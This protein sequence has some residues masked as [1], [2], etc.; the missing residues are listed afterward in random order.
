M[1]FL[2]LPSSSFLQA[3]TTQLE[4]APGEEHIRTNFVNFENRSHQIGIFSE[5][6]TDQT[7][8]SPEMDRGGQGEHDNTF[9]DENIPIF[10]DGHGPTY[11]LEDTQETRNEDQNSD[12]STP[13][14]HIDLPVRE[15]EL[16]TPQ[17]YRLNYR[18]R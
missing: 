1:D 7:E 14:T 2:V 9:F 3:K 17:F 15:F 11:Q 4:R 12:Y 18:R 6:D 16:K 10:E 5:T 13:N 8:W